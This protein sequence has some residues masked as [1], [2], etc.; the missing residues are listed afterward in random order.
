VI[1]EIGVAFVVPRDAGAPPTLEQLRSWVAE[2]LAD[3][4]APDRLVVLEDLPLTAMAKVDKE[5]LR[6]SLA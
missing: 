1:G 2:R 5:A 4:K 6:L 3:Y